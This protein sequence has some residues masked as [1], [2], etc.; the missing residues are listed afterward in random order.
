MVKTK[1]LDIYGS[2]CA[3]CGILEIKFKL[4]RLNGTSYYV[5]LCI[6]LVMPYGAKYIY[7]LHNKPVVEQL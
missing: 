2:W 3:L 6:T 4:D 5:C 1:F 7:V